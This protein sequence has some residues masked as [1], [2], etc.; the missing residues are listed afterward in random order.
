MIL[1]IM[2]LTLQFSA[3]FLKKNLHKNMATTVHTNFIGIKMK[4]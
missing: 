4:L 1:V 2:L 3:K